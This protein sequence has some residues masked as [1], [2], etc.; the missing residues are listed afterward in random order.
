MT[1]WIE[2]RSLDEMLQGSANAKMWKELDKKYDFLWKDPWHVQLSIA[3]DGF[4]PF[5]YNNISHSTWPIV[6]VNYNLLSPMCI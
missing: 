1:R 6:L 5:F 2:Y 4:N 3:M